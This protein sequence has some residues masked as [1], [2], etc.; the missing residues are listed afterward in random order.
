M[1]VSVLQ[2][3]KALFKNHENSIEASWYFSCYFNFDSEI[4]LFVFNYLG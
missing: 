1:T 3:T 2:V 4:V